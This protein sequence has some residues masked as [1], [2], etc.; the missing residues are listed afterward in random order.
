MWVMLDS[1]IFFIVDIINICVLILSFKFLIVNSFV[2]SLVLYEICR[3]YTY[4]VG[5]FLR[6]KVFYV[7]RC[8]EIFHSSLQTFLLTY[9]IKQQQ[10]FAYAF[11]FLNGDVSGATNYIHTTIG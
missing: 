8:V 7:I 5:K 10:V 1:W 3:L 6:L 2:T 11:E 9:S 4:Y